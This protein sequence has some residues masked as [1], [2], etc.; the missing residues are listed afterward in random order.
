MT[1]IRERA[2][3]AAREWRARQRDS[4]EQLH[5]I[6]EAAVAIGYELGHA[7]GVEDGARAFAE[8]RELLEMARNCLA[9]G[10]HWKTEQAENQAMRH[11]DAAIVLAGRKE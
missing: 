8:I 11:I 3:K 2:A 4:R 6:G 5:N 9:D 7:A 10:E 1:D